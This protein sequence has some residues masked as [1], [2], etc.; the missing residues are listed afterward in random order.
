MSSKFMGTNLVDEY[1]KHSLAKSTW[2]SYIASWMSWKVFLRNNNLKE[3]AV[4]EQIVLLFLNQLMSKEYSWA[5]INKTLAGVSFFLKLNS[6]PHCLSFFSVQ[7]ALKGYRKVKFNIDKRSPINTE[8]LLAI[9]R[10]A[11]KVCFSE[12]E[13]EMFKAVYSIMFF[14]AFR[15]SEVVSA[16]KKVQSGM[17]MTNIVVS[18]HQI[19]IFLPQ[20]KTDKVGKGQW[21]QLN[22]CPI[23]EICPVLLL[24]QYLVRRPKVNNMLFVHE[25]GEM[26]TKYQFNFVLK[27]NVNGLNLGRKKMSSH[28]FR[29]GAA[30]EA[31][32]VGLHVEEIKK[33]GRWRSDAY[34]LYI[35]P[36]NMF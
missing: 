9:C 27:K 7:Q 33:V 29:I 5:H 20:S 32:K 14:G 16:S 18:E 34:K 21:I 11:D 28:S 8:T 23:K 24:K 15:I 30:T 25:N 19:K 13:T 4:S 6:L 1:I 31:A 3:D 17:K 35:R 26:L 12:Y 22:S 2:K 36:N 10:S